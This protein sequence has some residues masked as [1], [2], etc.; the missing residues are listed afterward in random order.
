LHEADLCLEVADDGPGI[1]AQAQSRLFDR[2]YRVEERLDVSGSGLGLA[3][4]KSVAEAHGGYVYVKS[5]YV[6]EDEI[7][8]DEQ[9]GSCFGLCLPHHNGRGHRD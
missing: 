5:D 9:R 4:V 8:S 6:K 1:P 7:N 3:I 2:F